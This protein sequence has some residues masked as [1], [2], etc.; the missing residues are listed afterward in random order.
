M[1]SFRTD[2]EAE[3]VLKPRLPDSSL[4]LRRIYYLSPSEMAL[5]ELMLFL[6]GVVCELDVAYKYN[7]SGPT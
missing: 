7:F 1:T 3:P 5:T 2:R 4:N 6:H